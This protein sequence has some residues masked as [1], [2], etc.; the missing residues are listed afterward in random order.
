MR[1]LTWICILQ[2]VPLVF[3]QQAQQ[4]NQA[5]VGQVQVKVKDAQGRALAGLAIVTDSTASGCTTDK[6]GHC[7][8]SLPVG[9]HQLRSADD[10]WNGKVAVSVQPGQTHPIELRLTIASL[11]QTINVVSGSRQEELQEESPIK[12]EAVTR[13]QMLSTG[14]ERV[15][16][17]LQE[18]PGVLVR[19]GNTSTVGGEQIQGVDSRQVLVLQDGLPI[20]GARGIKSG[21]INLNRQSSDR[22]SR[23]EV[24]KGSGSSLY[25]SDAIGGVINMITREP[26]TPFETGFSLSGGSLG[27]IDGRADIGGRREKISYFLNLGESRMDAYRLIPNSITTVGPDVRRQDLLLKTRYQFSPKFALGFAA[28]AY[29]NRDEGRNLSETG[30]VLGLANDSTQTYALTADWI[31]SSQT[32]LQARGYAARYDENNLTTPIGRPGVAAPSNLNERLGRLDATLSQQIGNKHFLQVGGEWAQTLYRGAN[33]LVGDNVGQQVRA[34]DIWLQDKWQATSW[35]TFTLGGR[36]TSHSLF[37]GAAVPKVGA[38]VRLSDR[39]SLRG[40]TGY[41]FRAPDL[42][43]LYFRFANPANFYQV[44]GNPNL[45]PE[46]SQT[47]Q[48]GTNYRGSRYRIGVG[49]F[50]NNIRDLIDSRLIGTPRTA[51]ELNTLLANNGI[52]TFFDP[53]LNRQTFIYL[54]QARI[55]T[56]GVE[57][58]GE[59]VASRQVRLSGSYTFL[60]ALDR[61][62]RIALPQRHRHQG[63]M[64]ADYAINRW[65]LAMNLRGSFFSHWILNT[66]TGTRGLPFQIWDYFVSKKLSRGFQTF[67][68]VDN[69]N[70]SRDGKLQLATPTFDRPDF[71]R[72]YRI[73]LRWRAGAAE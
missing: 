2:V 59:F 30:P 27:V 24:A 36:I 7:V 67:I 52:P 18:I 17:V 21:A 39:W 44:I 63:Q 3:S 12:V 71:G 66:A 20:V 45:Q 54:N 46:H 42:G 11:T 60:N 9:A 5:P 50:R 38:V 49:L 62:T 28:N 58:D 48:L 15:S 23:V 55:F 64:R 51:N 10:Q 34:T 68:A 43:Q 25:G 13:E 56:Q 26:N 35:L 22:L 53:L 32:T 40:S 14:Y 4:D 65:G 29:R 69:L 19:R 70:N 37:G 41:G 6:T 31:F 16:D 73:G 33:R 1:W 47:F 61:N 57:L 8:F 72:T